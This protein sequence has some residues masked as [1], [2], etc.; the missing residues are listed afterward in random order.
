MLNF[1]K[2]KIHFIIEFVLISAFLVGICFFINRNIVLKGLYKDDLYDWSWFRG[3]SL[4]EFAIKFY[5]KNRYR[6]VFEAIQYLIYIIVGTDPFR[7]AIIN[8]LYN[9]IIAIIIYYFA[10]YIKIDKILCILVSTMY[11]ISHLAYYQIGQG[12]GS[13]ESTSILLTILILFL[14][15]VIKN[16]EKSIYRILIF[17]LYFLLVFNH[18]RFISLAPIIFISIIFT[19]KIDMKKKFTLVSVFLLE[20]IG[21]FVLRFFATGRV[22]PAGTG[23]TS[24]NETF[25]IKG[26]IEFCINQV[27]IILGIN[28]GPEH[29]MG[30]DFFTIDSY[31]IKIFTIVSIAFIV[32]IIIFYFMIKIKCFTKLKTNLVDYFYDDLLFIILILSL[33]ASSSVTIRIELRF[34]YSSFIIFIIYIAKMCSFIF[35]NL[36]TN[37]YKLIPVLLFVMFFCLRLPVEFV[38]RSYFNKIYCYVDQTRVNSLYDNTIGKYGLDE[39]LHNKKIFIVSKYYDMTKF[40]AEYFYKIYDKDNIGNTIILIDDISDITNYGNL[41]K[42]IV[43]SENFIDN[44]YYQVDISDVK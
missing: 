4:Y 1:K 22:I 38:Y 28:I 43:L 17:L 9:S 14:I 12:I 11:L 6:P 3:A 20:L 39:I 31:R 19:N 2:S 24:V 23:G 16:Q 26:F 7:F 10:R 44:T 32:L 25:T 29:L 30:I 35:D 15:F 33:I 5:S 42:A 21:I 18:E 8:K 34:V 37:T 36:S 13:I 40:Y 27:L 41:D